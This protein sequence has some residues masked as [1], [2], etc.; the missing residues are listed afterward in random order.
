MLIHVYSLY[1][2]IQINKDKTPE[3]F[4]MVHFITKDYEDLIFYVFY[5]KSLAK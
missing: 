3:G 5:L 2:C 1:M 4:A